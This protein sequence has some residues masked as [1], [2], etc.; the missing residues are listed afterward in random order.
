M[1]SKIQRD[2]EILLNKKRFILAVINE[3]IVI[4]NVKKSVII[5]DL[6]AKGFKM[7]KNMTKIKSTKLNKILNKDDD[8]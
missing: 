8:N 3:E 4:K 5:T 2:L 1:I 7:M 6:V